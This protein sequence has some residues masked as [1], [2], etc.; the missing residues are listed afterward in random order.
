MTH[1][2]VGGFQQYFPEAS[3][4]GFRP[5][6]EAE[7]SRTLFHQAC[8]ALADSEEVFSGWTDGRAWN[9]WEIPRFDRA[10]AERLI[11]WLGD[12]RARFDAARDAFVTVS[13]DE[14]E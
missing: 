14:E 9:G 7:R 4:S 2:L 5:V 10:E 11:R 13:Q 3:V 12:D 1:P 6:D 8:F